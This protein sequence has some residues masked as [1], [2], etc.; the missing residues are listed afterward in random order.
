[1]SDGYRL[2]ARPDAMACFKQ[3]DGS[4]VL[5]RNHELDRGAFTDGAYAS[6]S[7]AP[8][9]A[10][11]PAYPGGV[12][13]LVLDAQGKRLSSNLVLTGTARNCAGG[14]SPW[15]WLSCEESVDPGHGYVFL[16]DVAAE[17]VHAPKRIPAYGRFLHEAVA[18]DPRTS[19]AY[20]TEDR[21]EGCLYRYVPKDRANPFGPGRLQALMIAGSPG[22]AIGDSLTR[23][24]PRPIAWVDVPAEAGE[25]DDAL[26]VEAQKKGAALVRRGE[27]I[28]FGHDGAYVTST[29]GGPLGK[30]QVFHLTPQGDGGTVRLIAQADANTSMDMPDNITVTPWG[31]LLVCEDNQRDEYLRMIT[32][33]GKV[34]PFAHNALSISELAGVCFS[35]DGRFLFLNI[36]SN[37]LTL[38]IEGPFQKLARA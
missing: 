4:L 38:M 25:R 10:F 16:C 30:G 19:A 21:A 27:G 17:R 26:R 3:A 18:I 8:P 13:R 34:I 9:E 7:K 1:M 12:T 6:A 29:S 20:L 32:R 2:P 28:W 24:K 33:S 35:P 14:A 31:D 11:D 22:F 37:G 36:Q 5:M 15:G 23:D